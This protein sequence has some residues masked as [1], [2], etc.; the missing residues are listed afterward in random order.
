MELGARTGCVFAETLEGKMRVLKNLGYD[1][2]ELPLKRDEIDS[3]DDRYIAAVCSLSKEI[4]FPIK[5]TSMNIGRFVSQ[6]R[7]R[8]ARRII[9]KRIMKMIDLSEKCGADVILLATCEEIPFKEYVDIYSEELKK[10]A[11]YAEERGITLA[12]EHIGPY[13]PSILEKLV[14]AINHDAVKVYFDIG[15]CIWQGE[16]PVEQAKKMGDIIAQI[17]IKGIKRTKSKAEFVPLDKM[18]LAD[19]K[20]AL[21][22]HNY[23]GRGCL[24]IPSG[25]GN[26]D[27]L[28]EA[29]I[30]LRRAGY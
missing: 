24:E 12:L 23:K 21:E 2:L 15:N 5:S 4:G 14:R 22:M 8:E 13:K 3:M 29:L 25:K 30:I 1:F 17:H 10:P 6:F 16:D 9:V 11:D 28:K 19:V 27:P 7:E 26:N 18:P 20:E